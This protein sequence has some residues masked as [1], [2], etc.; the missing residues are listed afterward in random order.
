MVCP[1]LKYIVGEPGFL[2]IF[3]FFIWIGKYRGSVDQL[4]LFDITGS[5]HT[6]I[7]FVISNV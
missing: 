3:M 7:G 4:S 5:E 1:I 2:N 6:F